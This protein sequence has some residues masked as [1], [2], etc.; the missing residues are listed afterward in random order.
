MDARLTYFIEPHM[1]V[2]CGA[3]CT[4]LYHGTYA[5]H[6]RISPWYQIKQLSFIGWV[7]YNS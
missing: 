1:C 3:T 6:V 4:Q 7:I 2:N 5:N